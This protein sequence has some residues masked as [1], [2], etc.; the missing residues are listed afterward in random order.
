MTE[1]YKL[2]RGRPVIKK[3][4]SA[5]LPYGLKLAAWLGDASLVSVSAV[6]VGVSLDGAA[7][8]QGTNVAVVVT[9]L[10]EREAAINSCTFTFTSTEGSDSRTIYFTRR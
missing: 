6:A 7:F 10:D 8:I 9:G 5:R 1:T 3:T 4:P 2:V